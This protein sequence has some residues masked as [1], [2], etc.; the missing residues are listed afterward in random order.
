MLYKI[1]KVLN[2]ENLADVRQALDSAEFVDGKLSAGKVAQDV[3]NNLELS[4]ELQHRDLLNKAVMAAIMQNQAFQHA[5]LPARISTPIFAKYTQGMHYGEHADDPTMGERP[6]Q[7][8]SDVSLTLFLSEPEEYT[9]GELAIS[10]SFGRQKVKLDAGDMVVYPSS[11]LHQVMPVISGTRLVMITWMQS[12]VKDTAKR[13]I[14]YDLWQVKEE[15]QAKDAAAA[16]S[17]QLDISYANLLRMWAE[18]I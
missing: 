9:G 18:P 6:G 13:A 7:Y 16:S 10:T 1:A 12:M 4:K 5:A 17:R 2:S 11:S 15:L 8:R 14:L 3:K